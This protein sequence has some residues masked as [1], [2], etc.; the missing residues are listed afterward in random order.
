MARSVFI[1]YSHHD[2]DIALGVVAALEAS[3]VDV[4][5]APRLSLIHI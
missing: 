4:W 5:I 3:G 1:S 2:N